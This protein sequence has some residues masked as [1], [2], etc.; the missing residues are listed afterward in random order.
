MHLNLPKKVVSLIKYVMF[1]FNKRLGISQEKNQG[2]CIPG[3][4]KFKYKDRIGVI[5]RH[6]QNSKYLGIVGAWH[7]IDA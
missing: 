6:P 4:G 1:R 3:R 2:K 5:D 7:A